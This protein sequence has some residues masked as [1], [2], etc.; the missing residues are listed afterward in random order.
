MKKTHNIGSLP[1]WARDHIEELNRKLSRKQD[2]VDGIQKRLPLSRIEVD[3][4]SFND[5]DH[6]L[7]DNTR[8]TFYLGAKSNPAYKHRERIDVKIEGDRLCVRGYEG[9]DV[10]PHSSNVLYVGLA[11]RQPS[12]WK[13]S[14]GIYRASSMEALDNWIIDDVRLDEH[15]TS[16]LKVLARRRPSRLNPEKQHSHIIYVEVGYKS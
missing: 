2:A 11:E 3:E 9:L 5:V 16:T 8:I 14:D 6:Y 15:Y 10:V 13:I 12:V 1:K 7:P 4:S